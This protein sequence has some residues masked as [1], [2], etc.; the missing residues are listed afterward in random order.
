MLITLGRVEIRTIKS[1]RTVGTKC[2][3]SPDGS[4]SILYW[5]KK[6]AK[7]IHTMSGVKGLRDI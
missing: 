2:S 3:D 7:M 5:W 1:N 6:G 4:A